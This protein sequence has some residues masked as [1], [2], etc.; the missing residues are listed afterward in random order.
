[1]TAKALLFG[2]IGVLAETSDIQ[3]RAYNQAFAD[4]GVGWHWNS[5]TYEYLL[6]FVGGQAR[7]TLLSDATSRDLSSDL[8]ADIHAHKT[9]LAGKMVQTEVKNPR[10]GVIDAIKAAKKAGAAIGI[11]TSTQI[12]N[13]KAIAIATGLDLATFDVIISQEDGVKSKPDPAPYKLALKRLDMTPNAAIAVEDTAA[14]AQSAADAGVKTIVT[15]G[16]Y[17]NQQD[18][19]FASHVVPNLLSDR[20]SLIEPLLN[21]FV[22]KP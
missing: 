6:Q 22:P 1:M 15:P 21:A 11:V 20:G 16:A 17:A 14:S 10:P 8:I 3:R 18:F 19:R 4:K 12:Q 2:S 9:A 7:M 13:I 5:R